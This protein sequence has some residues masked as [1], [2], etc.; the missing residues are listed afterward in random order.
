MLVNA[1]RYVVLLE[2]GSSGQAPAGMMRIT[3]REMRAQGAAAQAVLGA[4]VRAV[5]QANRTARVRSRRVL[6][7]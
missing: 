4:F 3:F 5:V 6:P 1:V 2:L 7:G